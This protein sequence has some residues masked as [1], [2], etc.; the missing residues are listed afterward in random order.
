MIFLLRIFVFLIFFGFSIKP[1]FANQIQQTQNIQNLQNLIDMFKKVIV[2]E[3]GKTL[4]AAQIK[5]NEQTYQKLDEYF[6]YSAITQ[7]AI[8]GFE[9]K[10]SKKE[11]E[12]YHSL[13]SSLIRMVAYPNTKTFFDKSSYKLSQEIKMKDSH[14]ITTLIAHSTQENIDTEIGFVWSMNHSSQRIIDVTFDGDSLVQ[15]YKNQFARII[16]K[17]QGAGFL[18]K[19]RLKYQE[20]NKS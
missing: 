11:L 12:E 16:A 20:L 15:S 9:K 13:F 7:A 14:R 18:N 10:F 1:V 2:S 4:S 6:D 5:T 3:K 19:L 17:E 8:A